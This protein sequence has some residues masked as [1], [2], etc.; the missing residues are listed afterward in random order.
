MNEEDI[1]SNAI[2]KKT[3][4]ERA[5]YLNEACAGQ[6]E[7]RAHVEALLDAHENPDSFLSSPVGDPPQ[8]IDYSPVN[9]GPGA[10][11]GRYKL[12]EQIGKGGMGVV[13]VAEQEKPVRRKVALKIIKPG[14][15]TKEVIA[16]FEAERQA[17][18]LMDHPNIAKVLD[19][20]STESGR[21]Y[22]VMELVRGIPIAEYCDIKR[23]SVRERL[24]LFVQVCQAVQHAHQKGI[25]HRDIKPTNVLVADHDGKPVPKVIDF[26]VA[27]AT[28]QRLT[29]RTIYTRFQQMI[30]TPMYMSPE[31]A[32]FSGLDV[33][34]RSDIY[35]LGVLL[36]ELLTGT[37]PFDKEHFATAAYDE[38]RRIIR[39]EDPPKPSTK[40]SVLGETATEVSVARQTD[41]KRLHQV[42]RGDL[43]W[44]VVKA[45]EKDRTR[46]YDTAAALAMDVQRRINDEPI[47][48]RPPSASYRLRKFA[49]RNRILLSTTA[50]ILLLLMGG[51]AG[52]GVLAA[53]LAM[54]N[55][56]LSALLEDYRS[57][58][59][60]AALLLAFSGQVER[61][62]EIAERL[63]K[64]LCEL[65]PAYQHGA[66]S[67]FLNGIAFFHQGDLP[68]AREQLDRA[69]LLDPEAVG[70]NAMRAVAAVYD[71]EWAAYL[72]NIP[73]LNRLKGR[74]TFD[75]IFRC[76]GTLYSDPQA[77]AKRLVTLVAPDSQSS[78]GQGLAAAALAHAA[79][80]SGETE[81]VQ[82][83][84]ER[85]AHAEKS[86]PNNPFVL[87]VS[88]F[89]HDAAIQLTKLDQ[90]DPSDLVSKGNERADR[91]AAFPDYEVGRYE[92][93]MFLERTG[94]PIEAR[95]HWLACGMV[96][97]VCAVLERDD[98]IDEALEYLDHRRC[99]R[100]GQLA[101]LILRIGR[102]ERAKT[103]RD[104][105][106]LVSDE[107]DVAFRIEAL[108]L[109]LR[110]GELERA[111]REAATLV[112]QTAKYEQ[113][114]VWIGP[115]ARYLAYD[116]EEAELETIADEHRSRYM[117]LC[118]RYWIGLRRLAEDDRPGAIEVFER[119]LD[120]T[121][122]DFSYYFLAEALLHR[123]RGPVTSPKEDSTESESL[124]PHQ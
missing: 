47:E 13:Y 71:D 59:T 26:G 17:L 31:Q 2:E 118:A 40:I 90:G 108:E 61:T 18:A 5:A 112:P 103:L 116:I 80:D 114:G 109:L 79:L 102:D 91:L 93:A 64:I 28:N 74:S 70:P 35:S 78:F 34:T 49:Q 41:P 106:E 55:R 52:V 29:E 85:V 19:A 95:E 42:V 4:E 123:L 48:A 67:S 122:F 87:L 73:R 21:P 53:R 9:E 104:Y 27:K 76:Y 86:A 32:E 111:R 58:Q 6:A 1:F 117:Q 37:T 99:S 24:D 44:I 7:L 56:R 96:R 62:E 14:M 63:E 25:I 66:V 68:R 46:R 82:M 15:D 36:Y 11:I 77:A 23:L 88:L 100:Y 16:R 119:C 83:A 22:F 101:R 12:R 45:M 97:H 54:A 43:D 39:E 84:L 20:G 50:L 10:V 89:A 3:P 57:E 8:T 51:L 75:E 81:L 115:V 110:L 30:G 69:V 65:D 121:A 120:T 98:R 105:G 60:E 92:I 72:D 113:L 124:A 107:T 38:I 94:R 33:D